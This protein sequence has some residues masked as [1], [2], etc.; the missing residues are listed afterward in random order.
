MQ[1]ELMLKMNHCGSWTGNVDKLLHWFAWTCA[2]K[3]GQHIC[4]IK[5]IGD[6]RA[7]QVLHSEC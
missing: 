7:K 6:G 2:L 4:I 3:R 1:S 5:D